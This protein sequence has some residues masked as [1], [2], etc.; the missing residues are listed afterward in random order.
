MIAIRENYISA[1]EYLAAE[2]IAETKHEYVNGYIYAMAGASDNHV[3]ITGN[4]FAALHNHLRNNNCR[5]YASDMKAN[6]STRNCYYYPDVMVTCY[7]RDRLCNTYKQY[8]CLIVEV[9]SD[10]TEALGR[11]QKFDN[12]QQLASLQEYVLIDQNRE[13]VNSFRRVEGGLWL[14]ES[15]RSGSSLKL[16]S[17]DL[18]IPLT[19]IYNKADIN[20]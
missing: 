4:I 18:E 13:L 17:L 11:G 8:P 6:I 19:E 20:L 7:E 10:S 5:A 14:L 1:S 2:E 3:T 9:L 15:Y 16:E 12:Y